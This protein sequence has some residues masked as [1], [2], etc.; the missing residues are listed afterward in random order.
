MNSPQDTAAP[1]SPDPTPVGQGT[2]D[3]PPANWHEALLALISSRAG[4]IELESK[5]AAKIAAL[6]TIQVIA[7][8]VCCLFTWAL[9]LAGCIAA[10]SAATA[11]PWYWI[12]L[13]AAALHLLAAILFT[14]AAARRETPAFPATRAEFKKDREWIENLKK[15]RKSNV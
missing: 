2:S 11:W 1:S 12:A 5:D 15:N 4:L 3:P 14:R 8:G 7:A 10:L 6:K 13:G 9:I